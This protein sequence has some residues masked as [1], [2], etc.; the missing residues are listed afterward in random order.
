[1][2]KSFD[3][4]FFSFLTGD[5]LLEVASVDVTVP[6]GTW[7]LS[8]SLLLRSETRGLVQIVVELD[9]Q[10]AF[11]LR[12]ERDVRVSGD[13]DDLIESRL[14]PIALPGMT[15]PDRVVSIVEFHGLAGKVIGAEIQLAHGAF[16]V[17]LFPEDAEVRHS[18]RFGSLCV[19]TACASSSK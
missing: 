10:C 19:N 7:T 3:S 17:L 5:M 4:G 18:A 14:K 2:H 12:D 8:D 1:M 15:L 16:S 9:G 13:Y 11:E 6:D